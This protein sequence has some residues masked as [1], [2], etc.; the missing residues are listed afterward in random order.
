M[1]IIIIAIGG[2][3][4]GI[5]MRVRK[6]MVEEHGEWRSDVKFLHIDTFK[7]PTPEGGQNFTQ[8][9]LGRDIT[10]Q[11]TERIVLSEGMP[12]PPHTAALAGHPHVQAWF[13]V[14]LPVNIDFAQGAGG[15]RPYGRLAF[16]HKVHEFRGRL[17]TLLAEMSGTADIYILCSLF[18]GTGSGTFLDVCYVAR[19]VKNAMNAHG[20]MLGFFIIG[21]IAPNEVMQSNSYASLVELEYY[22]TKNILTSLEGDAA[23]HLDVAV[24][25]TLQ[26]FEARYPVAGVPA[27]VSS[28]A[29]VDT[30]YLF[31][32]A[33]SVGTFDRA[34][35][36]ELVARR[37]FLEATPG[38]GSTFRAKI[39]DEK[40]TLAYYT[41]DSL[42]QRAKTFFATGCAVIEFPAPRLMNALGAGFAAYCASYLQYAKAPGF[43]DLRR[44]IDTF[45]R[46]KLRIGFTESQ[47]RR[48]LEKQ[49]TRTIRSSMQVDRQEW[50]DDL[51]TK[52]KDRTFD[53]T[54]IYA[55]AKGLV[56]KAVDALDASGTYVLTVKNNLENVWRRIEPEISP[57][58]QS[59]VTDSTIGP[60][61]TRN[62][63]DKVREDFINEERKYRESLESADRAV[64]TARDAVDRRLHRIRADRNYRQELET[65]ARWLC[66]KELAVFMDHG[67]RRALYDAMAT[68]VR[69]VIAVL[70]RSKKDI[71]EYQDTLKT[72][73]GQFRKETAEICKNLQAWMTAD[74]LVGEQFLKGLHSALAQYMN[75]T[76]AEDVARVTRD[77]LAPYNIPDPFDGA[78]D[79]RAGETVAALG[80]GFT[81]L[82]KDKNTYSKELFSQCRQRFAALGAVNI[83]ELLLQ[84]HSA[85]RDK[86]FDEKRRQS[87]WPL[88]VLTND[89]TIDHDPA[90]H[91]KKWVGVPTTIDLH[92]HAVWA[93]VLSLYD[94]RN[95]RFTAIPQ[96][97]R[98]VFATST[99][100][101][102]LRNLQEVQGYSSAYRRLVPAESKKQH[103]NRQVEYPDLMP[104]DPRI[105]ELH[106]RAERAALLGKIMGCLQQ[107]DNP[108]THEPAIY[109]HYA[110][111]QTGARLNTHVC[112]DWQDVVTTLR[113]EQT[114]KDIDKQCTDTTSLERLER[115]IRDST[116]RRKTRDEKASLVRD[117][118]AHLDA[119][120]TAL[121]GNGNDRHPAYQ[122]D[123]RLCNEFVKDYDL[124]ILV[125][126]GAHV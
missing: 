86:L 67:A 114:R 87:T 7:D 104:P 123:V 19:D 117:I 23:R 16:H 109:L 99:S 91:D 72:L 38:V 63:I 57:L 6:T 119:R 44:E 64:R 124:G 36:E 78:I 82:L 74:T 43:R 27:V 115:E 80:D 40:G 65:H 26:P 89:P 88:Q 39:V 47:L 14:G 50:L 94:A 75:L 113:D 48:E 52:I 12:Q 102:C 68:L 84:L 98:M 46:H 66:T 18:G 17:N 8:Q 125:G 92:H 13:P 55:E 73:E 121:G 3:G 106:L 35:L 79:R 22:M 69:R 122:K 58:I 53:A 90:L 42:Q 62:F 116:G 111:R 70:D 11:P 37:V 49:D 24:R 41:P 33:N 32:A 112:L 59:Y 20:E 95:E 77:I 103:T 51:R 1:G 93:G 5:V 97:Y 2:V 96:P 76:D 21:A 110:D 30:C 9:V 31:G 60:T 28:A 61:H 118:Q 108:E 81:R 45:R 56:D 54:A 83:C 4:K 105:Q 101:F 29:P 107:A 85:E 100:V 120:L 10:L 34:Q 71:E 25:D 15:I 126:Q